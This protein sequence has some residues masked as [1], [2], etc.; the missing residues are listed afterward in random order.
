VAWR[1]VEADAIHGT[2]RPKR[3]DEVDG[4]DGWLQR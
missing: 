2:H 4:P 1:K 3:L